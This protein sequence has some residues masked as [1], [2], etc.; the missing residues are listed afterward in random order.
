MKR[1][2]IHK[3]WGI[4][5]MVISALSLIIGITSI[6]RVEIPHLI[7]MIIAV[8]QIVAGTILIISTVQKLK[9]KEAD[10]F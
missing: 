1:K 8:V 4:S 10:K 6:I 3:I 5:L 7:R 9:N 2:K